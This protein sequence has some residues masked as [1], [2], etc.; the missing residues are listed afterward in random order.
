MKCYVTIY[1]YTNISQLDCHYHYLLLLHA[2]V[3]LLLESHGR[4]TVDDDKMEYMPP[5]ISG[6]IIQY[7]MPQ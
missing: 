1:Y 2:F 5:A 7:I 3:M 6:L 4:S